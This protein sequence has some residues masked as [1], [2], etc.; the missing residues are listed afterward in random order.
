MFRRLPGRCRAISTMLA[1]CLLLSFHPAHADVQ[2][3]DIP[4]QLLPDAI[5]Q[6]VEK[7]GIQILYATDL[8]ASKTSHAVSGRLATAE[9]LHEMLKGSGL[10]YRE[11][12]GAY[13]LHLADPLPQRR[14]PL[15]IA[16]DDVV[17]TATRTEQRIED[18]PASAS[19]ITSQDIA[20]RRPMVISDLLRD[21]EGVDISNYG[22][23]GA[24]E[25]IRLRGVGGS[26]GGTT[27]PVLMDGLPLESPITGIHLGMKA[28]AFHDVERIEVA[29]GPASAL[30]GP[31]AMGG[32]VNL[33]SKRWVGD[34]SAELRLATGSHDATLAALA[35]GGAWDHVDIR[36]SA[37]QLRTDG[38]TAQPDPDPWGSRDIGPRDGR[39][40]KIA[41]N[42]ALRPTDSQEI[43]LGLRTADIESPWLGGHPNYRIN[44]DIDSYDLGYRLELENLAVIKLRGRKLKQRA[45]ISF[46]DE[47][48]NGNPGSLILAAVDHRVDDSTHLEL[49]ADVRLHPRHLLTVGYTH[50]L[51]R[52]VARSYYTLMDYSEESV[53][54]S[55]VRGVF[56]QDEF[57][58]SD[59]FTLL[60]GGRL[61]HYKFFGDSIDGVPTLHNSS[62]RIFNPRLGARYRIDEAT[63]LY[64]S[65]GTAYV[66]A[67]NALKFR[68]SAAWLN[69]PD[70]RP[71]TS[72]SYELG[73]NHTRGT[74]A[75]RLSAFHTDYR[76][77]IGSIMV[78]PKRQFQNI[79]EVTVNGLEFSLRTTMGDWKPYLNYA[80]TRS[81]IEENPGEP[82]TEGKRLAYISPHKLNLGVSFTPPAPYYA[83][84][85]GRYVDA[86]YFTDRNTPD[87]RNSGHFVADATIGWRLPASRML[88]DAELG[89]AIN[90]LFDRRYRETPFEYMDGRNF[91]LGLDAKF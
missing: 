39:D 30:Y 5:R 89:L 2:S 14:P 6:L 79:S 29:R 47:Y 4:A 86:W 58:M 78:G 64:A 55:R 15:K 88:P 11:N 65:A 53:S 82:L 27:S 80:Y 45:R 10:A 42:L 56:I 18:V 31:N 83:R 13:A 73:V 69:N 22:S 40:R 52:Y 49:Q 8:V 48:I 75:A 3:I 7:T 76:D 12:D 51:G 1:A 33:M 81:R 32:V 72:R 19:V 67:L 9:A 71:E 59:T 60:A 37:S 87:G 90:N 54:K 20:L 46:D 17:V 44:D 77:K 36:L 25:G 28:L 74:L 63:S 35:A 91:W 41:L 34:P 38:Y 43:T 68:T 61:D 23:L 21:V 57:R 84:F 66:P 16:S 62:D 24:A 70:L 50:D 26:F 85:A